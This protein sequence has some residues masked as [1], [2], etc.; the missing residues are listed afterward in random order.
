MTNIIMHFVFD[1]STLEYWR[2][3]Y[4][5][6]KGQDTDNPNILATRIISRGTPI[7]HEDINSV[8]QSQGYFISAEELEQ[9]K[10]I[11]YTEYDLS[12]K[13]D[14]LRSKY[15]IKSKDWA[16]YMLS[17]S[18]YILYMNPVNNDL[19]VAG[20]SPGVANALNSGEPLFNA[21]VL[22]RFELDTAYEPNILTLDDLLNLIVKARVDF[23]T[24]FVRK[25]AGRPSSTTPPITLVRCSDGLE[26]HFDNFNAAR[27]WLLEN[28]NK[29]VDNL[30]IRRRLA[31]GI[32]LNG[33]IY[34]PGADQ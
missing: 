10:D 6:D 24:S 28:T 25:P 33:I 23:K 16:I 14:E 13:I 18:Y 3:K 26:F 29:N 15:P 11:T 17:N 4:E 32:A 1:H 31:S 9:L 22:S 27:T 7:T 20:G 12:D 34:K 30:T 21:F 2:K 19:L 5:E 8:L